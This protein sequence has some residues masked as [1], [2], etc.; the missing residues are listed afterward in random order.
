MRLSLRSLLYD[1]VFFEHC[2]I[3]NKKSYWMYSPFC[4][5]CWRKIEGF[6]L[7][8]ITTGKFHSDF[9]KY[10]DSLNSFGAYEGVLKEAI[11]CFKYGGIKRIGK[12][13]GRLLSSITAPDVEIL[14]PVPLHINKL[15]QR[16]FNQSAILA[17]ECAKAWKIPLSLS[18]LVKIKNTLD[19]ASL[20]A[21]DRLNNVKMAYQV[22]TLVKGLKIGLIDD[23]VTTG[24][25]L[26]ECSKELKK[27]GAKEVHAIT[28]ARA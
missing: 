2:P 18:I 23:V 22:I 1:L 14:I 8:K 28:L 7:H 11:H 15:R 10:V 17:K 21:K 12:Q 25:T 6:S 13:L 9:W 16:Q 3:C 19:Q 5:C 27:A 24:A 4:E 26:M 20:D